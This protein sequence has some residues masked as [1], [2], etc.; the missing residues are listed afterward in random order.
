MKLAFIGTLAVLLGGQALGAQPRV[1][2]GVIARV[3][4]AVITYKDVQNRIGPNLD[5]LQRQ[6]AAQPAAYERKLRELEQSAI[7]ELVEEQ[8]ILHEFKTAGYNLPESYIDEEVDKIIRT[9]YGDRATMTKTL[10]AQGQTYEA[11]R[12]KLRERFIVSAM[13]RHHV[14]REPTISPHKI[15]IYW[16]QNREKYKVEDQ[17]KLRMIVVPNRPNEPGFSAKKLAQEILAKIKEGAP[18]SEMARIYSQGSQSTEGGDWK[19]IERS[20]LRSDLAEK[21]FALKPTQLS[22]VIE[23]PDG[24]YLMLVEGTQ[25]AHIKALPDVRSEIESALKDEEIKRLRKKWIDRLKAKSFVM[26]YPF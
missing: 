6:F 3:N 19:W 22:D 21:A 23:A 1:L 9:D 7:D 12:N 13:T 10:Q 15:E 8:L 20:V 11:Y 2:N 24:C 17:V 26:I 4:D 14:P 16:V 18:F 5:F 25:P